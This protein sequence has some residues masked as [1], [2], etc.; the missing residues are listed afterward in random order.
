MSLDIANT[1]KYMYACFVPFSIKSTDHMGFFVILHPS[2]DENSDMVI[3][4]KKF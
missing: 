2:V 4:S 3:F 1:A